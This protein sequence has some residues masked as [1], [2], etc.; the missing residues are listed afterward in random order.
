ML[1]WNRRRTPPI[2]S[3]VGEGTTV[4]GDLQFADGLRVD[5]EVFGD[6]VC[7][8][9]G[10]GIVVISEKAKVHGRVRCEH[11]I[12]AGEVVGPIEAEGLVELQ[13]TARVAGDIRY[14]SLEIHAGARIDGELRP[15]KNADKPALKL[16]ASND[17]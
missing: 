15:L 17:H 10:A 9:S 11:V 4:R 14:A 8:G 2:R 13:P 5:G 1:N 7:L 6:V 12:I 16:A 3:L